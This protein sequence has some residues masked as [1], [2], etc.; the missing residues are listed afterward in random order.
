AKK[1]ASDSKT[2]PISKCYK[3]DARACVEAGKASS[4]GDAITAKKPD[5]AAKLYTKGCA[6]ASPNA[7]FQLTLQI[8]KEGVSER[9]RTSGFETLRAECPKMTG[10]DRDQ[11][12]YAGVRAIERHAEQTAVPAAS[13]RLAADFI[14][15]GCKLNDM[16]ACTLLGEIMVNGNAGVTDVVAGRDLYHPHSKSRNFS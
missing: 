16:M 14:V 2:S 10:Y 6:L 5:L 11:C 3:G 1:A 15:L 7:C 9:T 13:Y 8:N 12:R 4:K